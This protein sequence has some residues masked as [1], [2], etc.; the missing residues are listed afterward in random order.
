[1]IGTTLAHYRIVAK[2]G[3]GGMGEVYRANDTKLGRD[4]ALK[5]LPAEMATS[6]ERLQRFRREAMALAVLDHPN[7]VTVFSVEEAGGVPFL[8]MQLVEGESLDQQIPEGGLPVERIHEIAIQLAEA[9]AAAHEK[10]LIHRDL[11]PANVTVAKDG[12]VKVL[13]F[14]LA[15]MSAAQAERFGDEDATTELLTREGVVV[16]TLPYMS[17][18]QVAGRPLD[19]RTD[20]FSLGVML[21]EMATGSRPFGGRSTAELASSILRDSPPALGERRHDLPKG[22]VQAIE[23]CLEKEAGDRPAS[24]RELCEALRDVALGKALAA[25]E[26]RAATD[27]ATGGESTASAGADS[28]TVPGFGGRPTIAVLPFENR[29]SD[30][31]QEYFA[32]GLAEDLISRLSLWRAFPVIARNSSFTYKGKKIDL[33]EVSATLGARYVVEGSVRKAGDRV[34]IAAQLVDAVSGQNVWGQSFDRELT[35]VFAVQDEISESIAASLL[36]DLQ[37]AE[38]EHVQHRTPDSLE[39]WGL[40]QRALA[41]FYRFTREN[42]EQGRELLN[43]ATDLEPE[44]SS[45]WARLAEV[46]IWQ[47]LHGWT[48]SPDET[49]AQSL[50]HAR[51][52]VDLD[53]RNAE[54]HAELAFA[55]MTAGEGDAAIEEARRGR[56]LNPSHPMALLFYAYF[57]N[58]TGQPPEESIELVH[59]AMRLS[60]RDPT[61]WLFY[62]VL[63]S[64]YFNAGLYDEGLEAS[65]RLIALWPEYYF[66]Q[67]W[68]AMNA[69]GLGRMDTAENAIREARRLLPEISLEMVRRVLGA[70]GPE[71]DRRMMGALEQAGLE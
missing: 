49:L 55:L 1:M 33:A 70:M 19:H 64:A 69:V 36:V 29:S 4:V 18:E 22:L 52:A 2:I 16:G 32:D 54:A 57:W 30:P 23:G 43:R 14:G 67:L 71:V 13:D 51:K 41:T 17:P 8:T 31:E 59:R 39:A 40:Y 66:G 46:G 11:K 61:E 62:D 25:I 35:D 20:L 27:A 15:R 63:A 47:I 3:E 5:V 6:S 68:C 24:A 26:P 37:H 9:L 21:Y 42:F 38:H 7:I 50:E 44:F 48:D 56:E 10:G 65:R 28:F 45:A 58:M 34:R 60:P 12:R 53:P